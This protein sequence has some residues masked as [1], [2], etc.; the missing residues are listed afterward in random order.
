MKYGLYNDEPVIRT[1]N[2]IWFNAFDTDSGM[3]VIDD[4]AHALSNQ[5]RFGGHLPKFYSVAQH[6]VLTSEIVA[7][8]HRLA[9]LMHDAS[10]AYLLD[11]P[12]P[13]KKKLS[14]YAEIEYRIMNLIALKYGFEWPLNEE[15]K[16]ADEAMLQKEWNEIMLGHPTDIVCLTPKFA[17]EFF[18]TR[19]N[20]LIN[21]Q[22]AI[23]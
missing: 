5:C 13:I 1:A 19:F 7:P 8:E 10:E 6:S 14:N 18:I 12:R 11:I 23:L 16:R 17:K 2:G 9:A 15:V 3:I 20:D 22:E 4:I 21:G